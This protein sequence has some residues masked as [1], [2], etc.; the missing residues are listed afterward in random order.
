MV[1]KFFAGTLTEKIGEGKF[2]RGQVKPLPALLIEPCFL[3]GIL[4]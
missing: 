1:N 3:F 2:H 4:P